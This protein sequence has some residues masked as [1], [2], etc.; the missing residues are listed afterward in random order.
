[1]CR[2][3]P[4]GGRRCQDN[5]YRRARYAANKQRKNRGD[6]D[7][8]CTEP[9]CRNGVRRW[10]EADDSGWEVHRSALCEVCGGVG[11]LT[12]AAAGIREFAPTGGR[13]AGGCD[14]GWV[15]V[16]SADNGRVTG[17]MQCGVCGPDE[18]GAA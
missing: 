15:P 14:D 18:W 17:R 8:P 6:R 4:E 12:D 13:C 2:S 5:A 7:V 9:D 16:M 10:V 3:K 1:M 11:Y